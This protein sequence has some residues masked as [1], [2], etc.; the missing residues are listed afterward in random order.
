M[1]L[2]PEQ[3]TQYVNS[4]K[5]EGL[6][7]DSVER[8][9]KLIMHVNGVGAQE[10]IVKLQGLESEEEV[11][12]RTMVARSNRATMAT[13]IRPFDK[14]FS[15]QGGSVF[16]DTKDVNFSA[17][18]GGLNGG[19]GLRKWLKNRWQNKF[20][21]DPNGVVLIEVD[22]NGNAEPKYKSINAIHD[23]CYTGIKLDYIIFNGIAGEKFAAHVELPEG[24]EVNKDAKYYR[25]IDDEKDTY[26]EQ[27]GEKVRVLEE[28]TIK[29][30]WG[31][32]P[33]VL[34]S[35]MLQPESSGKASPVED[36]VDLA[37]EY[38]RDTSIHTVY[39]A[40]HSYPGFWA[41]L[42]ECTRCK[43]TGKIEGGTCPTCKGEGVDV[44]KDVSKIFAMEP[45]GEGE[46]SLAPP[47]GYVQP[48]IA[49]WAEQRTELDWLQKLMHFALW[50]T[51]TR[52]QAANETATGRFIDAQPVHDRLDDFAT[53]TENVEQALTDMIGEHMLVNYGG[54][55]VAYGRRYLI[56]TPETIWKRYEEAR[57]EGAPRSTLDYLLLQFYES[58]FQHQPTQLE[59]YK[60]IM[61]VEPFIHLSESDA[62]ALPIADQD[63]STK[64][65]FNEWRKTKTDGEIIMKTVE[66]LTAELTTFVTTKAVKT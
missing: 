32:V 65:Y 53:T 55:S 5:N 36:I 1:I 48:D 62:I 20:F 28:F 6:I 31:Y 21:T 41:Y 37:D 40:L 3:V 54:S 23:Y 47:M 63:K 51:H 42:S 2:T 19:I 11:S 10:A 12:L 50:G 52:E 56:E 45:P 59:V 17:Y 66:Q 29:N 16:Y 13:L 46:V 33:G 26:A 27:E 61:G 39:K 34:N 58:E 18:I 30:E 44:K 25:L 38:L 9:K 64:I 22:T 14:I 49:S 60:K 15:A 35:D 8:H 57:K 4:P 24:F 7:Q 43:G